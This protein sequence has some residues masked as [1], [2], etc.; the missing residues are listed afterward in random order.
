MHVENVKT[1]CAQGKKL[2]LFFQGAPST[3]MFH[4]HELFGFVVSQGRN[5]SA[6]FHKAMHLCERH[7]DTARLSVSL[8]KLLMQFCFDAKV[9]KAVVAT[10]CSVPEIDIH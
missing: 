9:P 3:F 7:M 5:D 8:L 10:S 1:W 6:A 4:V 2:E